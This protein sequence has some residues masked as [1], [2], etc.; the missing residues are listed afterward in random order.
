VKAKS[1]PKTRPK[2]TLPIKTLIEELS[3][4]RGN[5]RELVAR[6]RARIE[7]EIARLVSL[8]GTENDSKR[9]PRERVNDLREM[10]QLL[11]GLELKPAKGRRRELKK[12]EKTLGE[13]LRI[14]ERW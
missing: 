10:L 2:A 13:L 11:R 14:A 5:V 1:R 3:V 8:L 4:L 12:I 9:V 6:Y 7:G